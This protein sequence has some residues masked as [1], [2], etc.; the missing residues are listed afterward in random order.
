MKG[1]NIM[2][3]VHNSL[4]SKKVSL[5]LKGQYK[6]NQGLNSSPD[7][8]PYKQL[9]DS[10]GSL[11]LFLFSELVALNI[12]PYAEPSPI[13]TPLFNCWLHPLLNI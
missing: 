7:L 11:L 2:T 4:P 10:P 13:S 3:T 8:Y 12:K 9:P 1:N 5:H 6:N